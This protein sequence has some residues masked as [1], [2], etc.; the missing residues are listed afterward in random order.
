M[1]K[2]KTVYLIDGSAIAYRSY[3]GMIRNRL[4]NSAGQPTGAVFAYVNSLLK[5]LEEEKPDYIGMVFDAPEKTFRHKIYKEYKATREAMP[6]ELVSQL[7]YIHKV[8]EAM[9]IPVIIRPGYEADDIIGTL[10]KDGKKRGMKVFMVTGDKDFMQLLE[11]DVFV[12]KPGSGQK[13]VE[14]I[15]VD[16][17]VEKWGVRPDQI[18]DY[19]GMIGDTSDNIPGIKGV[20]PAKARPLLKEFGSLEN[21]IENVE[22]IGN[23]R[24]RDLIRSSAY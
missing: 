20:G 15:D 14:I 12:Y 9:N 18:A 7:P 6:D 13:S 19:L 5:L 17:V 16:G 2:K 11:E 1:N 22:K 10:A 3:F 23:P 21:I 24:I 8:T 4:T